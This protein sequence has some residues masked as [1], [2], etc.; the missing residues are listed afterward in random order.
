MQLASNA[1]TAP[2][3]TAEFNVHVLATS[4]VDENGVYAVDTSEVTLDPANRNGGFLFHSAY[5]PDG[6]VRMQATQIQGSDR[7]RAAAQGVHDA[8]A[9]SG[10]LALATSDGWIGKPTYGHTRIYFD[11]RSSFVEFETAHPTPAIQSV[12]DAIAAWSKV[13]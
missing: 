3:A 7:E 5:M 8:I 6:S 4:L 10:L 2:R 13:R 11:R 12:L 9:A 1:T